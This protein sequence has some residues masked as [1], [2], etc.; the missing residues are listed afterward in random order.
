[1]Y[2]NKIDEL[3]DNLIDD[4]NMKLIKSK[5]IDKINVEPNFVKFQNNINAFIKDFIDSIDKV[6]ITKLLPSPNNVSNILSIM[7]RYIAYYIYLT[8][9]YYY[10]DSRD[11]YITNIIECSKNQKNSNIQINDFFNSENNAILIKFYTIIKNI[12]F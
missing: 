12:L 7:T 5:L 2:I 1:M 9:T 4:F 3:I 11:L 10:K 8:I 6:P